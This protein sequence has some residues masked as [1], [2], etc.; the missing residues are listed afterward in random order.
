MG[1]L[2]ALRGCATGY[3]GDVCKQLPCVAIEVAWSLHLSLPFG[4]DCLQDDVGSI[5]L[6]SMD[7]MD[8]GDIAGGWAL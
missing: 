7:R 2:P 5:S 3:V 6:P 1:V 4:R 8:M